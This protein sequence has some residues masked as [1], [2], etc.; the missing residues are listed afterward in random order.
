MP[1][2][3]QQ[4]TIALMNYLVNDGPS[5]FGIVLMPTF[6]YKA[7][8]LWVAEE[9]AMTLLMKGPVNVDRT[10]FM[11]F[12]EQVDLR[13]SRPMSYSGRIV[14]APSVDPKTFQFKNSQLFRMRRTDPVAQL[15]TRDM[16]IMEDVSAEAV[17]VTTEDTCTPVHGAMK[18]MQIGT[19]A[20]TAVVD[21][22]MKNVE[23]EGRGAFVYYDMCVRVPQLL[24]ALVERAPSW[25]LPVHYV[26]FVEDLLFVCL[27]WDVIGFVL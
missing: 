10:F 4:G 20:W 6:S 3:S 14:T 21:S 16:Q 13:D 9:I 22:V 5:N 24:L 23:F 17:P 12:I 25:N 1:K 8:Q 18:H 26:G 2:E 7:G 11:P 15:H 19:A 27:C